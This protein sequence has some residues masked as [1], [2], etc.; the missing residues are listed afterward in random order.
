MKAKIT[1][2]LLA[3]LK[4]N[5]K[6]VVITDTATP[7]LQFR[8]SESIDRGAYSV[9][10][11]LHDGRRV[12][13]S[14]GPASVF[15]PEQARDIAN[16]VVAQA[17]R[18]EDPQAT[19][20]SSKEL[21]FRKFVESEY[22]PWAKANNKTG[23]ALVDV[24]LKVFPELDNKKMSEV[25]G[26][27]IAKAQKRFTENG[28]K[29][30]SSNRYLDYLRSCLSKAVEWGFISEHPM[31]NVK[32]AKEDTSHVRYLSEDERKRLMDAINNRDEEIR[33]KRDSY[34]VWA[35]E[36]GYDER[37]DLRSVPF[38]DPFKPMVQLSLNTGMRRGEVFGLEWGG[39]QF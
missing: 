5:G 21:T 20:R 31:K 13:Y 26:W 32:S 7:G 17:K 35:R 19:K 14:I 8:Y 30:A 23:A 2:R 34:N 4:P 9:L 16:D 28:L 39:Y 36:R 29:P 15:S 38:V 11:R 12:R 1:K 37:P 22:G 10:Y 24:L 3:T 25:S 33:L 6:R 27:L 18:G